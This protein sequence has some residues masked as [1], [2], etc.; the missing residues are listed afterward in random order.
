MPKK[1]QIGQ[2][3]AISPQTPCISVRWCRDNAD[4]RDVYG[5]QA[6][7]HARLDTRMRTHTPHTGTLMALKTTLTER[8]VTSDLSHFPWGNGKMTTT[9]GHMGETWDPRESHSLLGTRPAHLHRGAIL[10]VRKLHRAVHGAYRT[11]NSAHAAKSVECCMRSARTTR[12]CTHIART[13]T[14]ARAN[15]RM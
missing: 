3:D 13:H 15:C 5:E 7:A 8:V 9:L 2:T 10:T 6:P 14:H 1:K 4:G 11:P 12:S